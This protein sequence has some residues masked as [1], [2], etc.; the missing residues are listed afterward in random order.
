[1]RSHVLST[2][3][4]FSATQ[5]SAARRTDEPSLAQYNIAEGSDVSCSMPENWLVNEHQECTGQPSLAEIKAH[6][7]R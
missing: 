2:G 4:F 5:H 7:Q 6:G 1:M 3:I